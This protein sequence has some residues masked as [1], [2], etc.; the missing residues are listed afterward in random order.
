[1]GNE[2]VRRRLVGHGLNG[3]LLSWQ[4]ERAVVNSCTAVCGQTL[5][6]HRAH[7]NDH[8]YVERS[9]VSSWA[10]SVESV[11]L[12]Y[13]VGQEVTRQVVV[14]HVRQQTLDLYMVVVGQ[15]SVVSDRDVSDRGLIELSWAQTVMNSGVSELLISVPTDNNSSRTVKG[16]TGLGV[17]G[18]V[19][20][21]CLGA[22]Q[23]RCEQ[24]SAKKASTVDHH[25]GFE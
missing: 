21:Q 4:K 19:V 16:R 2:R 18:L 20:V 7:V 11:W 9:R 15:G 17:E 6:T 14:L 25:D 1:M 12:R 24:D 10:T 5:V 13:N 22:L 3:V 23:S 8:G